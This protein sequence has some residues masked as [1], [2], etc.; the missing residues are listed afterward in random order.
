MVQ[1]CVSEKLGFVNVFASKLD[2]LPRSQLETRLNFIRGDLDYGTKILRPCEAKLNPG[3]GRIQ[4]FSE[5]SNR[6]SK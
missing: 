1:Q 2:L 3:E 4:S 6:R 5:L